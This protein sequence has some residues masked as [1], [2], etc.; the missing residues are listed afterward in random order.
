MQLAGNNRKKELLSFAETAAKASKAFE[1]DAGQLSEDLG[2]IAF[3]YKVPMNSI[4]ALGDTLNYLDDNTQAKG[5]DI[6]NVMQR[7]GDIADKL[8]Y[9]QAAALGSTF[10]SLGAGPEIAASASKAMV[11]E[12]GIASMQSKR[13]YEGM[14]LLGLNAKQLE[15]GVASNAVETIQNVLGKI[16]NLPKARQLSVMTML[17]G[18]EFGDDAQKLGLNID[19]FSR[20]L[21]LTQTKGAKGSMQRE[22]D[23]DKD[24]LSAQ[25]LLV[26]TGAANAMSSLG[27]TLRAPLMQIM[28]YIKQVT[29][30]IRRWVESN[31]KLA[32]TIM[33][34]AAAVAAIT[35]VL[36]ALGLAVATILG[37]LALMRFGFS[38]LGGGALS[39]LLPSF[40]GLTAIITRLAPGLAGAG[41]GIRA[42]LASLQNTNAA[43]VIER[44][45]EAL[46]GFGGDDEEGGLLD[47]LRNGVLKHLKEQAERA[48]GALVAA[49]R[50][51]VATLSALRGHVAGLATAGFGMLG[52]AVSR[53]GNILL[54]LVTSPLALLR[55]AL[56]ATGGLLGA[57]L[58]P[59]GLVIMALSAVALVVWKYWQPITAFLFGMVEGFQ[60]A[61]G[62]VKEAFEPL[63]PVFTW[64]EQTVKGLWKSFTDLLSPVKFTSDELSNAAD[65]GKRFGQALADGLALVMSPLESLK[66]GVSYLLDLMGLVSDESKKMPDAGKVTGNAYLKYGNEQARNFTVSGYEVGAYDSGGYLPA[67]KM[68][69]VGEN[70]PELING[71]VNIM[72]RRRTAALA[73]ATA[74]A[75]GSLSQPVAAKPLHPLSLPMAEYRQPSAGLRGG[76][77]SVSSGPAKYEINIHQAPG[78]SAQD[79]VAEVMRQLDARER[80]RAAGL[81]SSFSDRGD[82]E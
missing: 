65:M 53:F 39:R 22:S 81:R 61:A 30:G 5:A 54:A 14:A 4:E 10:L 43:S 1:I 15:E 12:L 80:Q 51:P 52:T 76:D 70:G 55:T 35:T 72:S 37:P 36:G 68:G 8:S 71:P 28:G 19:E 26:K 50:N 38:F 79:V 6:I 56:M 73:A 9:Q 23:I 60:A 2:K 29:G 48:G 31:P 11:R 13:F 62:P 34:V 58:S 46:S 45:R 18:K 69:I 21:S 40:G 41:G 20:Q 78:Q 27:E 7:M 49:F 24:S 74:M 63:R 47:A 16:K 3:L 64:I 25:W 42:F 75:F 59:V 44:I 17:F 66:S 82:F 77:L 32:G 33:K 67:G 57:L